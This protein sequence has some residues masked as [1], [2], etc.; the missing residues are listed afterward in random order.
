M[1]VTFIAYIHINHISSLLH[2]LTKPNF[3]LKRSS[4]SKEEGSAGVEN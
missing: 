1:L 3:S 2:D 4:G